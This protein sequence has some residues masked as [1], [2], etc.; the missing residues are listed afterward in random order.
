MAQKAFTS[1]DFQAIE[2]RSNHVFEKK[3][4]VKRGGSR[5]STTRL[6]IIQSHLSSGPSKDAPFAE[7]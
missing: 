6:L 5:E 1:T 7:R 4:E 2:R 3:E